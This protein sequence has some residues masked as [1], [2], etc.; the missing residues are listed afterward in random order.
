MQS[1]PKE[2]V[3]STSSSVD[4]SP[5]SLQDFPSASNNVSTFTAPVPLCLDASYP[6]NST[7]TTIPVQANV[8]STT[9]VSQLEKHENQLM[10]SSTSAQVNMTQ[11]VIQGTTAQMGSS[12]IH[13]SMQ[14][15]TQ[16]GYVLPGVLGPNFTTP[17]ILNECS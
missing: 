1:T 13:V 6:K 14:P 12:N 11:S 7:N 16:P 5:K 9:S 2:T 10:N 8:R 4:I 17:Q 15:P 3:L